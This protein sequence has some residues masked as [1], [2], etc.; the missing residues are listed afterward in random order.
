MAMSN[1]KANRI[2]NDQEVHK[3]I[4]QHRYFVS[5]SYKDGEDACFMI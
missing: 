5:R 2:I 4:K 3:K 1:M